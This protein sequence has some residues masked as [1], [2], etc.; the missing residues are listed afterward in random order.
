MKS[1]NVL[2]VFIPSCFRRAM[3]KLEEHGGM[4]GGGVLF[5]FHFLACTIVML[6]QWA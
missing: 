5:H 2:E 6:V 1:V 3:R 4:N